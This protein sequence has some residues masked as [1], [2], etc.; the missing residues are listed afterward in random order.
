MTVLGKV[1]ASLCSIWGIMVIALPIGL[2]SMK[3]NEEFEIFKSEKETLKRYNERVNG[4]IEKI[5]A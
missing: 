5:C 2:L 4:N 1:L 3:F